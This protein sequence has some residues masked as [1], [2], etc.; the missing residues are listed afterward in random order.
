[1]TLSEFRSDSVGPECEIVPL[2]NLKRATTE[3]EIEWITYDDE[4]DQE[5]EVCFLRSPLVLV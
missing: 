4:E 1:V 5:N 2:K 3:E